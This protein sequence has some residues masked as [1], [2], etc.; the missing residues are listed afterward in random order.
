MPA[1]L[2]SHMKKLRFIHTGIIPKLTSYPSLKGLHKLQYLA[3]AAA[4]SL[5]E[6]PSLEDATDLISLA[7]VDSQYIKRLPSFR[8]TKKLRTFG[9]FYRNEMCCNG[10]MTGVCDL[11]DF[12]CKKRENAPEVVCLSDK[13]PD[14]DLALIKRQ[15]IGLVCTNFTLD[16]IDLAPTEQ[17][18]DVACGGVMYRQCQLN[19]VTGICFNGR[20]Q[21]VYCDNAGY[22]ERM[23]RL[24][25]TR[26]V[27]PPC[28]PVE[29]AWLGCSGAI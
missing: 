8:A 26:K 9:L 3:I 13:I 7:I 17:L 5:R 28:D 16:I 10:Y 20:M 1:K 24:Q 18:T 12:Q 6:L 22:F 27:G 2:F 25:I 19:G 15:T 14:S 23:R 21:V 4:Y 11:T 29:E